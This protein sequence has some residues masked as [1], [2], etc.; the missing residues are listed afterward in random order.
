[1]IGQMVNPGGK[2]VSQHVIVLDSIIGS[3]SEFISG[4]KDLNNNMI[5]INN[6]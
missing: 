4:Y 5:E 6:Q 2:V 1:M 3:L